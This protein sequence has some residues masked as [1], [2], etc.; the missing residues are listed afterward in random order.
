MRLVHTLLLCL[1]FAF[2]TQLKAQTS[3]RLFLNEGEFTAV[4]S[5]TFP[6]L[7][8][9]SST[10]YNQQN[11]V[12]EFDWRDSI[13]LHLI[14]N[15]N[16]TRTYRLSGLSVSG[17]IPPSDSVL[18]KLT[19][20]EAK[21][22]I[23]EAVDESDT[24]LG[25]ATI[26]S[27]TE[28]SSANF[29]WNIRDHSKEVAEQVALNQSVN[30]STYEPSYFT[31]NGQS[32][33]HINADSTARVVGQVG[34]TIYIHMANTGRSIHSIHFHGYHCQVVQ[35][36]RSSTEIGRIKDTFGIYPGQVKVLRLVPHQSGEYPVHDHNLVAVT[37]GGIY[38]NGM[39]TTLLIQ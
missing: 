31:I 12:V 8:F 32:N 9:N 37:G 27:A 24:Y 11:K 39:F 15:T 4:D 19:T 20:P 34:D 28:T 22:W 10:I 3:V 7:A 25:L 18:L 16:Q 2:F 14:N 13:V 26:V 30:W 38:P 5:N 21:T 36:S 1:S 33:P 23:L 35:S 6:A 29:Y 17:Q